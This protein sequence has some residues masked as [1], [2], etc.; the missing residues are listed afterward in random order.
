M[1]QW[2]NLTWEVMNSNAAG[3]WLSWGIFGPNTEKSSNVWLLVEF[4]WGDQ[5]PSLMP[6]RALRLSSGRRSLAIV[7]SSRGSRYQSRQKKNNIT[8]CHILIKNKSFLHTTNDDRSKIIII[9]IREIAIVS[10]ISTYINFK[11]IKNKR[12]KIRKC[13]S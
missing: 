1:V 6:W 7:E 3:M 2:L 13:Y 11:H 4:K 10:N 9:H 8:F 5:Q 12:F